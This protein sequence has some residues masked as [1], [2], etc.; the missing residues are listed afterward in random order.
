MALELKKDEASDAS[1]LQKY[2][3]KKIK[4]AE[5]VGL[6][7]SPENWEEILGFLKSLK[8]G[9]NGNKSNIRRFV[10]PTV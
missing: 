5:G 4:E 7:A 6:F 3:I 9:R 8:G 2:N 10:E 1:E